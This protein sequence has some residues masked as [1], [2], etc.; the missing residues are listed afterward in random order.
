MDWQV[1]EPFDTLELEMADG[2]I[3]YVRRHGNSDGPR[4][5]LSHGNGLASDLYYPFWVHFLD[6]FEVVVFDLRNHGWNPVG[7]L[8]QHHFANFTWDMAE[9]LRAVAASWGSRTTLGALHSAS[10]LA[11][12]H[13]VLRAGPVFDGLVLFDPP[14]IPPLGHPI[15]Q[16]M[17]DDQDRLVSRT[18]R[19]QDRFDAP[20]QLVESLS[21]APQFSA[22]ATDIIDLYAHSTLKRDE[23]GGYELR[24]PR[25][26]E[27]KIY[28][29]NL[30]STIAM[31]M[32]SFAAPCLVLGGDPTTEHAGVPSLLCAD[33]FPKWG[34]SHDYVPGT[35]HFLQLEQP[36]QCAEKTIAFFDSLGLL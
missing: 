2:G 11:A 31:Q 4:I 26:F 7:S 20:A 28:G 30:D 9:V 27:A 33:L 24:C 23:A 25:E 3:I 18:L 22:V 16:R 19:R 21:R 10:S 17:L 36:R 14:L 29:G 34:I 32:G 8:R 1:P 35:G 6:R 13:Y 15:E 5:V 12:L